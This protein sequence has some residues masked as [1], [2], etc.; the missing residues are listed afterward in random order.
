MSAL[1]N[2]VVGKAPLKMVFEQRTE[3]GEGKSPI[4]R[5]REKNKGKVLRHEGAWCVLQT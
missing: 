1:L 2:K 5:E 3:G 4:S